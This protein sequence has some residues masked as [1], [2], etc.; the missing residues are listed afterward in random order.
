MRKNAIL[1]I[2]I[3]TGAVLF[4]SLILII[5]LY[6]IQIMHHDEYESRA[7]RQYVH[8]VRDL[9]SRGAIFFST[10]SG[11]K[12]SAATVQAGYLLSIDPSRITDEEDTF[13]QLNTVYPLERDAFLLRAGNKERTYVE[14]ASELSNAEADTIAELGLT[15]VQL[16]RDQWRYYPGNDLAA[17]TIGFV[18]YTAESGS[19]LTGRYG[20]ERYYEDILARDQSRL[21]VNFF[22]EIFSNLGSIIFDTTQ[23]R[24]GDVVTT[25]EP[26]VARMLDREL[27]KTQDTWDSTLTGG[28]IINP[29]TG[30]I[31]AMNVVPTFNLNDR[32]VDN[33][34]DFQNPLVEGVYEMGSIIKALT[35]AAGIDA[36]AVSPSTT[37]HDA[38][39]LTMNTFTIRNYDGLARGTVDMQAVLNQSLN[40]GVAFVVDTMGKD[41]FRKYFKALKFGS[42][43]G[44]DLPNETHGLVANLDSPRDIEYATASYGQG[45]ALTPIE[46][47]RALATLGNGGKLITPHLAKQIEYQDGTIKEVQYPEGDQVFSEETSVTISRMLTEVVDVALKG[48]D[49]K[50]ERYS[51]AAK[52]GTAQIADPVN[53]G[54]YDDRYLHSFFGY[55]PSYDPEFLVFLYTVEPKEVRYASQTLTEPF[56]EITKFL[57]NYYNV[58]PDR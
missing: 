39:S 54:Y 2:R 29:K 11:E 47:V 16:Y 12:V 48:G 27:I 56:M 10:K 21:S 31:Y 19:G 17:R 13:E 46:T 55:F 41:K 6:H 7:E 57:I 51:V 37:Y 15:G 24:T 35:M 25:I 53:G 26:T 58:P 4:L 49:V 18:G 43:T 20:L 33:I 9:Y 32:S 42:E 22:A 52:T 8:T 44:I 45:I 30:A 1:R 23:S 34:A 50:L 36:G 40:T 14:V 28:I 3:I 38:G 5:R